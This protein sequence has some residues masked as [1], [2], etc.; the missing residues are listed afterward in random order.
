MKFHKLQFDIQSSKVPQGRSFLARYELASLACTWIPQI[1]RWAMSQRARAPGAR[2]TL[3]PLEMVRAAERAEERAE[4]GAEER[5]EER[6]E[7]RAEE[8]AEERAEEG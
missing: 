5:A 4:K 6:P 8:T 3:T 7:E 2:G 1:L